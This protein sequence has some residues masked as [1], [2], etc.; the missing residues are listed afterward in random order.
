MELVQI[1]FIKLWNFRHTLTKDHSFDTQLFNIARTCLVDHLRQQ[2]V[3]KARI[4]D[5]PILTDADLA[6]QPDNSFEAVDYFYNATQSLPPVRKKIFM[7]HR[8]QGFTYKEIAH[9]L[10]ISVNT[11]EDHMVKAIRQ[12]KT[13]TSLFL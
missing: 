7:L 13:I 11:V 8:L 10:S 3:M 6:A 5:I 1:V 12:I 9:Q 2:S 4:I